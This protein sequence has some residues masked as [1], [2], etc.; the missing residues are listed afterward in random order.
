V[1]GGEL[2]KTWILQVLNAIVTPEAIPACFKSAIIAPIYSGKGKDPLDPNSYRDHLLFEIVFQER[3]R[4][5]FDEY[6]LELVS[7]A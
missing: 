3:L 1:D 7:V 2:L 6:G 4:P 5:I